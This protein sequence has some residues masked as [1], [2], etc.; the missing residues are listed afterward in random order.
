MKQSRLWVLLCL[1]GMIAGLWL[2][3]SAMRG[4]ISSQPWERHLSWGPT[5]WVHE[6]S[7]RPRNR[8]I[9]LSTGISG[10]ESPPSRLLHALGRGGEDVLY[11]NL[12]EAPSDW[13]A[14]IR[15]ITRLNLPGPAPQQEIWMAPDP[16]FSILIQEYPAPAQNV[17]GVCFGT[18]HTTADGKT[19]PA[20]AWANVLWLRD[21]QDGD[22]PQ[23][24]LTRSIHSLTDPERLP[25]H[26]RAALDLLAE[27]FPGPD[28]LANRLKDAGDARQAWWE[29]LEN[30]EGPSHSLGAQMWLSLTDYDLARSHPDEMGRDI[31]ALLRLRSRYPWAARSPLETYAL[32]A[33]GR[34]VFTEPYLA[35]R[36]LLGPRMERQVRYSRTTAEAA[37][38]LWEW[39][40]QRAVF[41]PGAKAGERTAI[42]VLEDGSGY[43][44]ELTMLY[45]L[46]ARSVGLPVR[47]VG[48]IWPTL[49]SQHFWVEVWD[50]EKNGWHAFDCTAGDR[51]YA[52][53]WMPRVP[54]AATHASTG[55]SMEWYAHN[56]E[57]F[58]VFTN[59]LPLF[60]PTREVRVEV[61]GEEGAW[62]N[63]KVRVQAWLPDATTSRTGHWFDVTGGRTDSKGQITFHLGLSA[64]YPYRLAPMGPHPL[65]GRELWL[66]AGDTPEEIRLDASVRAAHPKPPPPQN[67]EVQ[68]E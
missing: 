4:Q 27:S 57:R 8:V 65:E 35:W 62:A 56:E 38:R 53:P 18:H 67:R 64:K 43:C 19:G 50:V 13:P 24:K 1:G 47:P 49:G 37:S 20:A 23:G 34:R 3:G 42:Q 5:Y 25:S 68:D 63:G 41:L 12:G 21:A 39:M 60:L 7:T 32:H 61:Q 16:L 11:A 46:L 14:R 44:R 29:M 58:D 2:G 36:G 52:Y 54:K 33:G 28:V 51:P 48:T 10:Q 59:S 9:W 66:E 30:Q 15:E 45:T 6:D 22:S 17:L 40:N 31:Q 55:S 26:A